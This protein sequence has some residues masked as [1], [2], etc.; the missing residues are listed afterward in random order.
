MHGHVNQD[1]GTSAADD[2]PAVRVA[3]M[4]PL[5]GPASSAGRGLK[6][7]TG[8]KNMSALGGREEVEVFSGPSR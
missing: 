8:S 5:R 6:G 1:P 4:D 2:D 3:V 7:V